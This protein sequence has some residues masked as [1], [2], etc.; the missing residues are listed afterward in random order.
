MSGL[1]SYRNAEFD[2]FADN[3]EQALEQGISVSG[4]RKEFFAEGRVRWLGGRLRALSFQAGHVLDFGCGTG[5]ATPFLLA[6]P[7]LK[8]L[9]SV[10]VSSKS[11]A[12]ARKLH[13][14]ERVQFKLCQEFQP[15]G[16]IDLAFCNGVFHHIPPDAR[17][18]SVAFI[19]KALRPGGLFAMWENNP[20][21]PG[22]R[23]VMRRIPFDRDAVPLSVLQASQLLNAA[24][25]EI[26]YKDFLFIFPH[27]LRWFRGLEPR[28]C[29]FPLGAQYQVLARKQTGA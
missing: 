14:S 23:Y 10:E 4:E 26:I 5:S 20:W 7:G 13:V 6:L 1:V 16:Q 28:L 27:L 29:C 19:F 3:Y 22:T 12:I 2:E 21:N 11:I 25:F 18:D 24:G 9:T 17:R 15:E 8:R